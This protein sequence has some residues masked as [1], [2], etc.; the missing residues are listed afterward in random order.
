MRS[1]RILLITI[2]LLVCVHTVTAAPRYPLA[3]RQD[4][5]EPTSVVSTTSIPARSSS[6][7]RP[8]ESSVSQSAPD[9]QSTTRDSAPSSSI[10]ATSS[11]IISASASAT[12]TA[13]ATSSLTNGTS[14]GNVLDDPLPLHP[15][16][17][18]ALG[19]IGVMFLISG[20]LYA[21]VGIKNKW[22]YV[23][24]SAAYLASLAVTGK[25]K[26]TL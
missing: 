7:S 24:G 1:F 10:D 9:R 17:T 4:D 19:L 12:A 13:T 22:I 3:R 2:A 6:T 16:V 15:K 18:P 25:S 23:F 11:T 8:R 14:S 26:P 21:V 5:S 20:A